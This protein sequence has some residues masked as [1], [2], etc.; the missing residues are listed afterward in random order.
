MNCPVC[1]VEMINANSEHI[2]DN[3]L[4]YLGKGFPTY[5]IH[6]I[7]KHYLCPKCKGEVIEPEVR[8]YYP[9]EK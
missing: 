9:E 8:Y 6:T 3:N 7:K 5:I 2:N 4:H 1:N